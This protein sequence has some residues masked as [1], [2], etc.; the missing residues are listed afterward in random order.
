M[1]GNL[2]A[3]DTKQ[4]ELAESGI[5]QVYREDPDYTSLV[6]T[7]HGITVAP[8][9]V[10]VDERF[11][12]MSFSI[13]G[14]SVADGEEPGFDMVDVY[15]GDDPEDDGS[16]VNMSGTMYDGIIPD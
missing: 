7:D 16:R 15:Q 9:T 6:V 2:Q 10:I 12:Y 11:V 4:R 1:N 13:S 14:Y 3:S 5:A 8:D